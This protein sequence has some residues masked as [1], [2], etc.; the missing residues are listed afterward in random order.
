MRSQK[1]AAT[2]TAVKSIQQC[3]WG[4]QVHE[5]RTVFPCTP[6]HAEQ[7]AEAQEKVGQPF[8]LKR[9]QML[10][11]APH[12]QTHTAPSCMHG[13]GTRTECQATHTHTHTHKQSERLRTHTVTREKKKTQCAE[14]H[15]YKHSTSCLAAVTVSDGAF[16]S[17]SV[18]F[19]LH[20]SPRPDS[21][22]LSHTNR[23]N[24]TLLAT[25]SSLS[26]CSRSAL[27]SPQRQKASP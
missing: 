27:P 2:H 21:L 20:L 19:A 13:P 25:L 1:G 9:W 10:S 26:Y 16:H 15:I 18:N 8:T 4:V 23:Q 5:S 22:S 17:V 3:S 24:H 6:T 14:E 7:R 11:S 12:K